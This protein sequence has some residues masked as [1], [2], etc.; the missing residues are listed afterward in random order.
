[1]AVRIRNAAAA[2]CCHNIW[3]RVLSICDRIICNLVSSL[4]IALNKLIFLG[5]NIVLQS[6]RERGEERELCEEIGSALIIKCIFMLLFM[7]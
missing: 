4:I 1:M 5:H 2:A 7:V 3:L 6:E